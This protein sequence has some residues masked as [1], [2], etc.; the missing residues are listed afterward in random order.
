MTNKP[1][2]TPSASCPFCKGKIPEDLIQFGGNCPHCLLEIPGEE[3]PTDPGLLAR[4]KLEAEAVG[5]AKQVRSRRTLQ[6]V[7]VTLLLVAGGGYGVWTAQQEQA[8][9]TY[10]LPDDLYLP[11]LQEASALGAD[12]K[13][14]APTGKPKATP[15]RPAPN[16]DPLAAL[17]RAGDPLGS[18][19]P[20]TK[21]APTVVASVQPSGPRRAEMP[22][23]E[24]QIAMAPTAGGDV[25][26]ADV[27]RSR[28]N[29]QALSDDDEI[30]AMI[31]EVMS[32]YQ[33]QVRACYESR[34]KLN[35]GL[36]GAWKV[37]FVVK[38]DG[39]TSAVAITPEGRKDSQL[40]SCIAKTIE[41][42]KF[43]RITHDQPV[44][45]TKRFGA[46]G[47]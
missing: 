26:I 37:A 11:P 22:P 2:I 33:P 36:A 47:M 41:A 44:S 24:V 6:A 1:T 21:P 25:E 39:S 18:P 35:E 20:D 4:K 34:L 43:S 7:I 32:R 14:P 13:P 19:L 31:K 17:S 3:A 8:S 46:A 42:W 38:K 15:T 28:S 27:R 30:F 40:E 16:V 5:K 10:E 45:Q 29:D 23:P 9:R 12:P